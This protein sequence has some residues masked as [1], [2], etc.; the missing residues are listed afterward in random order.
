MCKKNDLLGSFKNKAITILKVEEEI[1]N[2]RLR[3]YNYHD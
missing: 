1:D 2:V 3:F